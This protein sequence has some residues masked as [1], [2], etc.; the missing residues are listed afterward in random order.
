MT[1]EKRETNDLQK[2]NICPTC[3]H[4]M[5]WHLDRNETQKDGFKCVDCGYFRP[6]VFTSLIGDVL[7]KQS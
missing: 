7:S 2:M 5:K 4:E 1:D 6:V 3:K